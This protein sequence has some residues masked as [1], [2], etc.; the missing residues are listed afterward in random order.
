MCRASLQIW[1]FSTSMGV[2]L[3]ARSVAKRGRDS[4]AESSSSPSRQAPSPRHPTYHT[5]DDDPLVWK[6]T[7]AVTFATQDFARLPH[8]RP[9]SQPRC[10]CH[11]RGPG[12]RPFALTW[13]IL[14][15]RVL[16]LLCPAPVSPV[17]SV[18]MD[19]LVDTSR[20]MPLSPPVFP[21]VCSVYRRGMPDWEANVQPPDG[22]YDHYRWQEG[23]PLDGGNIG[24]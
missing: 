2:A 11:R 7:R 13:P 19:M 9:R 14:T 3:P 23:I 4:S 6:A 21:D 20:F 17:S 24:A 12:R 10:T 5:P 22:N 8:S 18:P 16:L 15:Q 1:C